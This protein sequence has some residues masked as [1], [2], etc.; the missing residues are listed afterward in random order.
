RKPIRQRPSNCIPGFELKRGRIQGPKLAD[1]RSSDQAS[2]FKD[3]EVVLGSLLITDLGYF[4][5]R[6]MAARHQAGGYTL[7]RLKTGTALFTQEGK[8]FPLDQTVL[9]QR[10]GQMK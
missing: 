3:E 1:G 2:P 9:P 4:N 10:V 8:R 7:S 5:L 6:Q